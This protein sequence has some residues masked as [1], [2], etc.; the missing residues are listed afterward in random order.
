[1]GF[2]L[3]HAS[4]PNNLPSLKIKYHFLFSVDK[5]W[6]SV[7]FRFVDGAELEEEILKRVLDIEHGLFLK[8]KEEVVKDSGRDW[9][10]D[11]SQQQMADMKIAFHL[12]S[13]FYNYEKSKMSGSKSFFKF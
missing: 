10:G 4:S 6:K 13:S 11:K 1:M 5:K 3:E 7:L 9:T 8:V 12:K 2:Y